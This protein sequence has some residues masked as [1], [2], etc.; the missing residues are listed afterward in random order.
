M[1]DLGASV[2]QGRACEYAEDLR[3]QARELEALAEEVAGIDWPTVEQWDAFKAGV[4]AAVAVGANIL[5]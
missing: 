1:L 3:K 5:F 4:S 2:R